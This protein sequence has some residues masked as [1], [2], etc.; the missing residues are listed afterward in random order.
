[1]SDVKEEERAAWPVFEATRPPPVA[2]ELVEALRHQVLFAQPWQA[3]EAIHLL[4]GRATLK[5]VMMHAARTPRLRH[6][7]VLFLGDNLSV[8]LAFCKGRARDFALLTLCRRV[9]AYSLVAELYPVFRHVRTHRN[10]ADGPTRPRGWRRNPFL[11]RSDVA[12]PQ[13]SPA[14]MARRR[15]PGGCARST[16]LRARC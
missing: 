15:V 7:R 16:R 1:M 3:P 8:I 9:A 13:R 5:A 2:A 12:H 14:R 6:T 4:E 11:H 10:V